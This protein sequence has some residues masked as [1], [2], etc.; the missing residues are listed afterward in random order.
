M[1]LRWAIVMAL[2]ASA[3]AFEAESYVAPTTRTPAQ[4]LFLYYRLVEMDPIDFRHFCKAWRVREDRMATRLREI[5]AL[6]KQGAD[7]SAEIAEIEAFIASKRPDDL[8]ERVVIEVRSVQRSSVR[9]ELGRWH[10]EGDGPRHL[11]IALDGNI[12]SHMPYRRDMDHMLRRDYRFAGAG[13]TGIG[14]TALLPTF[15]IVPLEAGEDIAAWPW[16]ETGTAKVYLSPHSAE[17]KGAPGYGTVS[18]RVDGFEVLLGDQVV[19]R[20]TPEVVASMQPDTE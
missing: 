16:Q 14:S 12:S 10:H 9:N 4:H 3:G 6:E 20:S 17:P 13:N 2:V 7:A 8:Q 5:E 19:Y 11:A 1:I 18:Y 15:V